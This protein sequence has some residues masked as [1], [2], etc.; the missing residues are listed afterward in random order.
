MPVAVLSRFVVLVRLI[1][2]PLR[3]VGCV[4]VPTFVVAAAVG[5]LT[6]IVGVVIGAV[7]GCVTGRRRSVIVGSFNAILNCERFCGAVAVIVFTFMMCV[8]YVAE[9]SV[10]VVSRP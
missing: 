6:M 9:P 2:S 5:L 7:S 1:A 3:F 10:G 4:S 8:L